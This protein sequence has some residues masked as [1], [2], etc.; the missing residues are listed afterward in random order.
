MKIIKKSDLIAVIALIT[1]QEYFDLSDFKLI[2][3][4]FGEDQFVYDGVL[5][6]VD[7]PPEEMKEIRQMYAL[8]GD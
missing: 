5:Q 8:K 1:D 2:L 6:T 7:D 4:R 3:N